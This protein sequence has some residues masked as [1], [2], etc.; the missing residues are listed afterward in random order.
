MPLQGKVS[1][2][3]H[4]LGSVLCYEILCN[5]PHLFDNLEFNLH[6]QGS[7]FLASAQTSPAQAQSQP[8]PQ[9]E[10]SPLQQQQ[11]QRQ[12]STEI[13]FA[14][15]NSS[16]LD[17]SYLAASS[18][19]PYPQQTAGSKGDV[20]RNMAS[21]GLQSGTA[22]VRRRS[23]CCQYKTLQ[24]T[25]NGVLARYLLLVYCQC[26]LNWANRPGCSCIACGFTPQTGRASLENLATHRL[27][28]A[29]LA[30]P[31]LTSSPLV[32]KVTGN[33]AVNL[34]TTNLVKPHWLTPWVL[35][36]QESRLQAENQRL[37]LELEAVRADRERLLT[38]Q[39]ATT[40]GQ[41]AFGWDPPAMPTPRPLQQ[42]QQVSPVGPASLVTVSASGS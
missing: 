20:S 36:V 23:E 35:P 18:Y 15:M 38:S 27:S 7:T 10:Q 42:A 3:A 22:E 16:D 31:D 17:G 12:A 34:W 32:A 26:L 11:Q 1:L 33:P 13:A 37:Q 41:A 40:S 25:V 14:A 6:K 19:P 39:Q 30:T 28:Y 24:S 21:S 8:T 4:S 9:L 2:L 5:Q 29:A